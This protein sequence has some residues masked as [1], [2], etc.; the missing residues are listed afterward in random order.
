MG[1]KAPLFGGGTV[2]TGFLW[3]FE[4][5]EWLPPLWLAPARLEVLLGCRKQTALG[6]LSRG[7]GEDAQC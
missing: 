5:G 3:V 1:H 6:C 7:R 4:G 2:C